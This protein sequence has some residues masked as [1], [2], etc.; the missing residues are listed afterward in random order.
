MI[1]FTCY[2]VSLGIPLDKDN[3]KYTY[4]DYYYPYWNNSA[5][6]RAQTQFSIQ[7]L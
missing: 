3:E 2:I 7:K 6:V 5:D 4:Y 1:N